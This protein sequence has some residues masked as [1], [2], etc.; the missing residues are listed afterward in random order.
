MQKYFYHNKT[1]D[2]KKD[3]EVQDYDGIK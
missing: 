1:V 3:M 2:M